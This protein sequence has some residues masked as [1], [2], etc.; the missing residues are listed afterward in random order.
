M[1]KFVYLADESGQI[2][3]DHIFDQIGDARKSSNLN[4]ELSK[5]PGTILRIAGALHVLENVIKAF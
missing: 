3:F 1:G 2:Q 5:L 4:A